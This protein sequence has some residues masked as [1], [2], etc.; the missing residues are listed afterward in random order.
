[1]T[2]VNAQLTRMDF[3]HKISISYKETRES[4]YGLRLMRDSKLVDE[5]ITTALIEEAD[6]LAKILYAIIRTSKN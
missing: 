2:I 6:E 1:M 3:S 5:T 4:K